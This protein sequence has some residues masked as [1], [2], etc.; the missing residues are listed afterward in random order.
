MRAVLLIPVLVASLLATVLVACSDADIPSSV[1]APAP[2]VK[3]FSIEP[4]SAAVLGL[5]G[6]VRAQVE[7]PLSFQV[8][9]KITARLADTGQ[10]VKA[11]D[12]LFEV[13]PRDFEQALLAARSNLNAADSAQAAA[14]ADVD[15]HRRLLDK[16]FISLQ[17]MERVELAMREARARRDVAMTQLRQAENALSYG[18][19]RSP[20]NG[21]L[22][23]VSGEVGQVVGAGQSVALLAQSGVR[24]VEVYFPERITPPE[25]GE[26]VRADTRISL[27]LRERAA[28]VDPLGR[29]LRVRYTIMEQAE[30]LQLGTVVRTQF[31][32]GSSRTRDFSVPL[33][34][35]SERGDGPRVWLVRQGTVTSVPVSI[36]GLEPERAHIRAPLQAGDDI[37]ALGTH[38]LVDGM[39]VRTLPR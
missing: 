13:D 28:A 6:V 39:A 8:T 16:K 27:R 29:T 24:E 37:V 35:L 34:A 38:L 26:I 30:G 15:R 2:F 22:L 33:A 20:A 10:T 4:S 23:D 11:G 31:S 7:S 18:R 12:V 21:V 3:T 1:V 17:A 32:D 36:Q 14:Q 19:L 9:G 25:R 5:S